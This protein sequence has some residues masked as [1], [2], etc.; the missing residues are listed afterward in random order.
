MRLPGLLRLTN[1]RD[2]PVPRL[3]QKLQ[4]ARERAK[5]C[6]VSPPT[7]VVETIGNCTFRPPLLVQHSFCNCPVGC[8]GKHLSTN[9]ASGSLDYLMLV[10]RKF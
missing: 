8:L 10:I 1:E 9:C 6:E 7:A 3:R 2:F 4:T 5:P